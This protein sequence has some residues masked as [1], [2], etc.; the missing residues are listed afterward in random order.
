MLHVVRDVRM[1]DFLLS[2]FY[3]KCWMKLKLN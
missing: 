3:M 2:H 1:V